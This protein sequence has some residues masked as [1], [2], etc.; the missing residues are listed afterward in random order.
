MGAVFSLGKNS[1]AGYRTL[2]GT[3]AGADADADVSKGVL[4][5]DRAAQCDWKRHR[6]LLFGI[7][8][9]GGDVVLPGCTRDACSMKRYL[10]DVLHCSPARVR[11][12]SDTAPATAIN[13]TRSGILL[14]LLNLAR[15][16]NEEALNG[17]W[18]HFIGNS[19]GDALLAADGELVYA[20]EIQ[21]ILLQFN[22]ASSIVC[23]FDCDLPGIGIQ[24]PN[25]RI[26]TNENYVDSKAW[27]GRRIIVISC[28]DTAVKDNLEPHQA[29]GALSGK[30]LNI[31][32]TACDADRIL[33]VFEELS[34][35][36]NEP[37]TPTLSSSFSVSEGTQ[38]L[39]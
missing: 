10:E 27:D 17:C 21:Q 8:Y 1:R 15:Q 9:V 26:G 18:I 24:L 31:L 4:L 34:R 16:S 38:W 7:D 25:H 6:A 12:V 13:T 29:A 14:E 37:Y 36:V 2:R 28:L 11:L 5:M 19:K 3:A 30:L 20:S 22:P 33:P 23:V 35:E 39:F 32:S